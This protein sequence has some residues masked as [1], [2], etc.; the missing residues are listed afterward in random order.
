MARHTFNLTEWLSR[1]GI[2][3]NVIPDIL[4]GVQPVQVVGDASLLVPSLLPPTAAYGFTAA[5]VAGHVF[6]VQVAARADGGTLIRVGKI[7]SS[8][9]AA[10]TW[11]VSTTPFSFVVGTV[12][13]ARNY[14]QGNVVSAVTAGTVLDANKLSDFDNPCSYVNA[15][16][17]WGPD[18]L[19]WV[20]KGQF[21][22]IN[23]DSPNL[24][25]DCEIVIQDLPAMAGTE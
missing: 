23:N 17:P 22:L 21:F 4:P 20:P 2:K 15:R 19:V 13:T 18:D 10:A 12:L 5:G 7:T 16:Q 1:L 24:A 6:A 3:G 8:A 11:S 14:G 25:S 9:N